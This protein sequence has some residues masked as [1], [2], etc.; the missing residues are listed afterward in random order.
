M[1]PRKKRQPPPPLAEDAQ[2]QVRHDHDW[3]AANGHPLTGKRLQ[4]DVLARIKAEEPRLSAP[5][6]P[7]VSPGAG[8]AAA[9]QWLVHQ[10]QPT[11]DP[12][13]PDEPDEP[14]EVS[15]VQFP[16]DEL[17]KQALTR[18]L[19]AYAD[20]KGI[21][22]P[23][24]GRQ[25]LEALERLRRRREQEAARGHTVGSGAAEGGRSRPRTG[26]SG[27]ELRKER[28]AMLAKDGSLS[29]T[30]AGDQLGEKYGIDRRT[31]ENRIK[32]TKAELH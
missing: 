3:L 10:L 2:S 20:A 9:L 7:N 12:D 8:D 32:R 14:A 15:V 18:E 25:R 30:R 11:L 5:P 23:E 22:L 16:V 13:D 31:V 21:A 6:S 27:E 1:K 19:L 17:M 24:G 29:K 28:D 4:R 26:P